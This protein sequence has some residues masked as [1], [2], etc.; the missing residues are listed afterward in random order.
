MKTSLLNTI[1]GLVFVTALLG[2]GCDKAGDKPERESTTALP[3]SALPASA[4]PASALPATSDAR[5]EG[6]SDSSDSAGVAGQGDHVTENLATAPP[7]PS[8]SVVQPAA[9]DL[10]SSPGELHDAAI[11]ALDAGDD[12]RAFRLARKAMA[13]APD[14]PQTRFLMAR[15]LAERNRFAEAIKM[16][17]DLL[18]Q[19]PDAR[20]PIFGQTADWLTHQGQWD[21]AERR[22]RVILE[23][24]PN[25]SM[26]ERMLAQLLLRQ[27]RRVEAAG[28]LRQLCRR[29]VVEPSN[30]RSL[31]RLSWPFPEDAASEPLDPIGPLGQARSEISHGR[32]EDALQTLTRAASDDPNIDALIGRIHAQRQDGNALARWADSIPQPVGDAAD[33]WFAIASHHAG[34]GRH[35][36]AVECFCKAV[37]IDPTDDAAYRRMSRSLEVLGFKTWADE[38]RGRSELIAQTYAIGQKLGVGSDVDPEDA[39]R[40]ADLLEKLNRPFEALAWRTVDA[41]L[42]RSRGELS[43]QDASRE[44]AAINRDRMQRQRSGRPAATEEFVVCGV[45]LDRLGEPPSTP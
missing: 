43:D 20:L 13:V 19:M 44:I 26:A 33:Y 27:G 1:A 32:W 23:E 16:L 38:A 7:N 30:L 24:V 9:E 10:P 39:R 29:G 12:D 36:D 41:A 6:V 31:L 8:P 34:R 18:E 3:A 15:V 11:T 35:R 25:A 4:L 22:Y 5:P 21:E 14:D 2:A 17:D 42:R 28:Y 40:L 37:M 45:E